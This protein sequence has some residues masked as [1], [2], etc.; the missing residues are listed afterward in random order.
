M[1]AALF[2]FIAALGRTMVVANTL[3]SFALLVL[4]VLSGFVLSHRNAPGSNYSPDETSNFEEKI[5]NA[6]LLC[7]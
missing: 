3:A 5:C 7:S 6:G 4:L 1:A 2:R